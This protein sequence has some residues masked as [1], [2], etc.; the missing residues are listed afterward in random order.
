MRC[1]CSSC[2]FLPVASP[3]IFASRMQRLPRN[4][5]FS[6]FTVLPF[7]LKVDV[8]GDL[9]EDDCE[10]NDGKTPYILHHIEETSRDGLDYRVIRDGHQFSCDVGA[11][12]VRNPVDNGQELRVGVSFIRI[13]EDLDGQWGV[14][15]SGGALQIELDGNLSDWVFLSNGLR[16]DVV[17]VKI[18]EKQRLLR[19]EIGLDCVSRVEGIL[20]SEWKVKALVCVS[21]NLITSGW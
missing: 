16:L 10:A 14:E 11:H 19:E 20:K 21:I 2:W 7:C 9:H 12:L 1:L 8:L 17:E 5:A 4:S 13:L 3:L 6:T 15:D 18:T